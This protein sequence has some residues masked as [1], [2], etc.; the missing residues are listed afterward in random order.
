MKIS[1]VIP[2]LN[3]EK[4]IGE[5]MEAI[6][7][8]TVKPYEVIVADGGST[9]K[10]VQIALDYGCIV[11]E[12][13]RG[14]AAGG[15]NAGIKRARGEVVAFTDGDCVPAEDWIEKIQEVFAND[16]IDG[17]GGMVEPTE[18]ENEYEEFWGELS[19]KGIMTF[20]EEAYRVEKKSLNDAFIT[21]NC[22]YRRKLLIRIRGFNNW[23]ANNAEDV[24]ISWRALDTGATLRYEPRIKVRAHS[25]TDMRGICR[26]SFRNGYSSSKLQKKYGGKINFDL[27]LYKLLGCNVKEWIQGNKKAGWM[28]CEI[29]CHLAGKLYGSFKVKVINF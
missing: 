12:N 17:I 9:D 5:C 23:F 25:P 13:V 2:V 21:A 6:W 14:H 18:P 10:T 20:G 1:V 16:S 7:A 8:N 4:R 22:A 19:L 28:V 29:L 27:S 3:E 26:K 15:R 24:D 11:I